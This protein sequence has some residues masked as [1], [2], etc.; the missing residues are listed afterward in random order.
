M[1]ETDGAYGE[2]GI[3][4]GV[5]GFG[6]GTS[7]YIPTWSVYVHAHV[8]TRESRDAREICVRGVR[9][10]AVLPQDLQP[11]RK[12]SRPRR[13]RAAASSSFRLY[14]VENYAIDRKNSTASY[15]TNLIEKKI[16]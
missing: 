1:S 16:K 4:P 9:R 6:D 15:A 13:G 11:S 7:V 8:V 10:G 3:A 2:T 12:T 14:S 5:G